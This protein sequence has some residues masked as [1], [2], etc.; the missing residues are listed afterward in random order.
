MVNWEKFHWEAF[1]MKCLL[2][3]LRIHLIYITLKEN[4]E[5][6]FLHLRKVLKTRRRIEIIHYK[7]SIVYGK[8]HDGLRKF[9]SG[10]IQNE[11]I[12]FTSEYPS[13]ED[14]FE[15]KLRDRVSASNKCFEQPEE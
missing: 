15:S 3:P 8:H 7:A 4:S 10:T 9:S 5:L 11:C 1:K 2:S 14:H 13:Y 12:T 6:I